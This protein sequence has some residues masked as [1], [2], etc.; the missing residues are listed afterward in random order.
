[1][2]AEPTIQEPHGRKTKGEFSEN[3]LQKKHP[4]VHMG[5]FLIAIDLDVR[6]EKGPQ[7]IL[8]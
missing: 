4:D 8:R 5:P 2:P 1:M 6:I 3:I 7:F